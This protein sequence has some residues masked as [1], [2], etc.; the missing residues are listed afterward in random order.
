MPP[1]RK[2]ATSNNS[3]KNLDVVFWVK[4]NWLEF[5]TPSFKVSNDI[6]S[7]TTIYIKNYTFY[8]SK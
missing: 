8:S 1:T 5:D 6:F 2:K 3:L 4:N 7:L